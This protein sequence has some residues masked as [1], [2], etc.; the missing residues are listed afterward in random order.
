MLKNNKILTCIDKFTE[1]TFDT[2]S[3]D[4]KE[5]QKSMEPGT[6]LSCYN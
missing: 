5:T 2:E 3:N 4:Y 1:S 6:I